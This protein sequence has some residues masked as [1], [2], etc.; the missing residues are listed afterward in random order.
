M[1]AMVLL[2]FSTVVRLFLARTRF[3]REGKVKASFFK[4]YQGGSEPEESAKLARHFS[5]LFEAP[6]LFYVVCLAALITE[7]TSTL[8]VA[9]AWLYVALRCVHTFIHT[10]SNQIQPRI[11]AYF[12]SWLV[13]LA[14]W[15]CVVV[16][17]TR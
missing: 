4:T 10:G 2:T 1:F 11:A 14:L 5:N 6:T 9:L 13:L 7:P 17:A 12:S 15:V 8:A 3:V 16:A